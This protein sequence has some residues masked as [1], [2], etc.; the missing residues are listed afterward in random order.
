MKG[1]SRR[2]PAPIS[3][4]ITRQ[5]QDLAR[6]AFVAI[7]AAGVAR[8]DFL[9][10]PDEK[11]YLNEINTIPGSLAFYLWEASDVTFPRLLDRLI[12][13]ARS[14]HAARKKI[15]YSFDSTLLTK[16]LKGSGKGRR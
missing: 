16:A 11:V 4:A 9:L 1:L 13:M 10:T 5:I 7:D 2:I 6:A 8:I 15:T 3:P 14:R 12:D